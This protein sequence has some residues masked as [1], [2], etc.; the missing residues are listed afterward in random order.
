M[1]KAIELAASFGAT[2]GLALGIAAVLS[3]GF[4]EIEWRLRRNKR[5]RE[6]EKRCN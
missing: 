1:I 6:A 4:F 5:K 3:I 2:I